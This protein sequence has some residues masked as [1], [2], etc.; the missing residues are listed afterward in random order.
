MRYDPQKVVRRQR[1]N[2]K[3]Q[4]SI[5]CSE[6]V[7]TNCVTG[8]TDNDY[9][10]YFHSLMNYGIIFW[11]NSSYSDKV[12]KLQKRI[13]ILLAGSMTRDS[14][15]YLFKNLNILT[16]PSQYIFSLSRFVITSHDQ[17]T[18]NSE[19]RGRNTRQ[20]QIFI[21]QYLIYQCIKKGF[22]IW[23]LKSILIYSLP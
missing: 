4:Y 23:V 2:A 1:V 21:N 10:A 18:F 6:N 8:Y 3:T 15:H 12:F 14:S 11:G 20:L 19:I 5:L 9:Y 17:Y 22:V 13:V 16:L 7:K